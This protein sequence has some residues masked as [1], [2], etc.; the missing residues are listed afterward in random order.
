MIDCFD[1][2]EWRLKMCNRKNLI[3]I[4][5]LVF[6]L[7]FSLPGLAMPESAETVMKRGNINDDFYAAGGTVDINAVITGDVVAAGGELF[8]GHHIKGDVII[9]GGSIQLRGDIQD[10]VRC[11][12]GDIRVDANIGDDLI[13]S[14]GRIN[15]SSDSTIGGEA[16]LAGGE[17]R[18]AGTVKKDLVVGAGSIQLSGT[19]HGD[20]KLEGGEIMILEGTI[21][22]GDLHYSSPQEAV[23]HATAKIT[24][25]VTY[26][27]SEWHQPHRGTGIFFVL[28]MIVASIVLFKLFPG[29][30]MA[31]VNRISAD[32][33]K[34][35]GAG[36]LALVIIPVLAGL[37]M[38]IVLGIWVSLSIMAL[39]LVALIL[40]FLVSCFYLGDWAVRRLNKDIRTTR[41]RLFSV[42]LAIFVVGLFRLIPVIGGLLIFILLLLGLGAVTLQL[43]ELYRQSG[44]V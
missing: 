4:L 29:F 40:S 39:Y 38:A 28:T 2:L 27:Q 23:I 41:G 26:E 10:D 36:F 18:V 13:A 30:T 5:S 44:N 15:V 24:G 43:K 11:A 42:S 16:W 9:A 1:L 14:G 8:I 12:G 31:S 17:V 33:L 20:V 22:H 37:L 6:I 25:N 7:V 21:I 19:V 32:P 3:T 34:S 35:L